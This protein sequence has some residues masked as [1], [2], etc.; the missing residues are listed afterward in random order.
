VCRSGICGVVSAVLE[1]ISCVL[2]AEVH[3]IG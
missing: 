3:R 1:R 2:Y